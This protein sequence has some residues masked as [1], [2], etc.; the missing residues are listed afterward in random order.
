VL[1]AVVKC[2][3]ICYRTEMAID[4][5]LLFD[6]FLV[7]YYILV[8]CIVVKIVIYSDQESVISM[9]SNFIRSITVMGS[10]SYQAV[11]HIVTISTSL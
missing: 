6:I 9:S 1:C 11:S 4:I 3:P 8:L 5:V 10:Y 2:R 7:S